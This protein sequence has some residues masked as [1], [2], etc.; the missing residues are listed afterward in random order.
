MHRGLSLKYSFL[1]RSLEEKSAEDTGAFTSTLKEFRTEKASLQNENKKLQE[2]LQ[3]KSAAYSAV[4]E[5]LACLEEDY[6][7]DKRAA[8]IYR[9]VSNIVTFWFVRQFVF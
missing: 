1:N 7:R 9:R 5:K 6:A 8:E 2:L 3:Q 4:E